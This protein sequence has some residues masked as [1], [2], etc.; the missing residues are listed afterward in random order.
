LADLLR[1]SRAELAA[2]RRAQR[3]FAPRGHCL[4]VGLDGEPVRDG[5][6]LDL[7]QRPYRQKPVGGCPPD[8]NL[9][10]RPQHL[11]SIIDPA[12]FGRICREVSDRAC[13]GLR[14]DPDLSEEIDAGVRA[15]EADLERRRNRLRRRQSAGDAMARQ[16]MLLIERIIPAI[17]AP[18][19]RLDAMG[20]LI[21][22]AQA[23]P[24]GRDGPA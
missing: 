6:L 16:D 9:G 21:V 23:M 5:N 13:S 8:L 22:G 11:A 15:A 1:P 19:V 12:A 10:S 14:A 3:Y 2:Q 24:R 7:L 4:Y 20:C 17:R 18:A